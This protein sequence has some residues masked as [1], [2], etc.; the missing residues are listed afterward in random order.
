MSTT[1]MNA[2]QTLIVQDSKANGRLKGLHLRG[3]RRKCF[4]LRL[5]N[6]SFG[7]QGTV[8]ITRTK[9]S[10]SA[11]RQS[12]NTHSTRQQVTPRVTVTRNVTDG[13]PILAKNT[14]PT[15]Q[16][17]RQRLRNRRHARFRVKNVSKVA[18]ISKN[19]NSIPQ[20]MLQET[21]TPGSQDEGGTM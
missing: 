10:H 20:K 5:T 21:S 1:R 9:N 7:R 12:R 15:L 14:F 19:V 13:V 6:D 17:L 18:V 3:I 16:T 2:K 8:L 4:L 11:H